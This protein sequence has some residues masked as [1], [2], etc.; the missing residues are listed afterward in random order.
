MVERQTIS[1]NTQLQ[2]GIVGGSGYTGSELLRLLLGHSK[3]KVR[4][5]TS[6]VGEGSLVTEHYPNLIGN[7]QAQQLRFVAPQIAELAD[8]DLVFFATPNGV[9]MGQV[10]ELLQAGVRIIDLSADFRLK[11]AKVWG[12]WYGQQHQAIEC[13][14]GAVYG[15]ADLVPEQVRNAKLVANPGCFTTTVQLALR[16]LLSANML[17]LTQPIIADCKSGATGAGRSARTDLSLSEL[18]ENF[19]AYGVTGHRHWPELMQELGSVIPAASATPLRFTFVPHLLPMPRGIFATIYCQAAHGIEVEQMRTVLANCYHDSPFVHV[20][21]AGQI[22]ATKSVRGSN[23]CHLNV[24]A[25][26]GGQI[27]LLS[28]IDNLLKGAAGQAIQNMNL[29]FGF[30][31]TMG[32]TAPGLLP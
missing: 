30:E 19:T 20:L 2:V 8:L 15:L 31:P 13:L 4:A 26:T 29:M 5:I 18:S 22:P 21:P 10:P 32:L 28:A 16:P 11:D 6:R 12:Q 7:P 14:A 3:V 25:G 17:D 27:V 23:N 1:T 9:A 24:V